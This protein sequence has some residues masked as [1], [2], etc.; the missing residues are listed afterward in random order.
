LQSW[1]GI[2]SLLVACIE[3]LLL[4][5]VIIFSEKNKINKISMLIIFLLMLYQVL[6]FL[7][8]G[9][10]FTG[11][12][13]TYFAFVDITFLPP[14]SLILILAL[15]DLYEKW[16]SSIFILSFGFIIFYALTINHFEILK[17][18]AFYASYHYPLGDLYGTYFYIPILISIV[19]LIL[20]INL[21]ES[22]QKTKLAK[23][24]LFG[25]I[26]ISLPVI[27]SFILLIFH[28][29]QLENII[30]S[31]MCKFALVYA[32]CLSY[33]SLRYKTGTK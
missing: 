33:F 12:E 25:N 1:N 13:F 23:V 7:I 14:F 26:F 19:I 28:N 18:T 22:E 3:L 31:V 4:I 17:C 30:E 5:N 9:L 2:A 6:E 10:N 20:K 32:I 21:H 27:L 15:F 8:C 29:H 11:H 16:I 24:L